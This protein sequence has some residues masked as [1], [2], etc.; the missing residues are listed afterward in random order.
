MDSN[1]SFSAQA[2][3]SKITQ[4]VSMM[5]CIKKLRRPS[6]DGPTD[7]ANS[8]ISEAKTDEV[9]HQTTTQTTRTSVKPQPAGRSRT[10]KPS[11]V[12]LAA[13]EEDPSQVFGPL[14]LISSY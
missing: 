10:R 11:V 4:S 2:A 6:V 13:E 5:N 9:D 14:P 7:A 1:Y 3:K 12:K 8:S